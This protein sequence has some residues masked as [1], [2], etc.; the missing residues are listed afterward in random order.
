[1]DTWPTSFASIIVLSLGLLL[2]RTLLRTR[3]S[4]HFPPGPPRLPVIGNLHQIPRTHPHLVFTEWNKKYGD[5]VGLLVFGQPA[6]V[7]G[8][9]RA[10]REILEKRAATSSIRPRLVMVED[11]CQIGKFASLNSDMDLHKHYRRMFAQALGSR[12]AQ[13]YWPIQIREMRRAVLEILG[14]KNDE[15]WLVSVRRAVASITS[16]IVYAY[17]AKTDNDAFIAKVTRI[18]RSVEKTARPGEYVVEGLTFLKYLPLWFPGAAFK[19]EGLQIK[20]D[21]RELI[22]EP[23]DVVRQ[24]LASGEAAP[25]FVS[26]LLQKDD[27]QIIADPEE[28]ERVKWAAGVLFGGGTDTTV[29]AIQMFLVAILLFPTVLEKAQAEMDSTIGKDRLPTLDDRE[30]LPYC[31]ALVQE[32][33]RWNPVVPLCIPHVLTQDE[34]YDGHVLPRGSIVIANSWALA[35]DPTV[36]Q[37]PE[38]FRPERFLSG[39]GKTLTSGED[40]REVFGFGRRVCPGNYLAEASIF[41]FV[42]TFVWAANMGGSAEWDGGEPKFEGGI[43]NRPLKIPADIYPRSAHSLDMLR[44]PMLE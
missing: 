25:C 1:M 30:T 12:A 31:A 23:Y 4:T 8:S 18:L 27:G 29:A 21:C 7:L 15:D 37:N 13:G 5:V 33:L 26:N 19:R 24:K 43:V 32:V 28:E 2:I 38:E 35:R 41:A 34:P 11:I 36:Y 39:D 44:G 10:V 17:E 16:Q 9:H 42:S 40:G 14:T 6:V 3:Q 20:Q 22:D